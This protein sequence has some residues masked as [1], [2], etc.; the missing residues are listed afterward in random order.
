ML[1]R[2]PARR[3]EADTANEGNTGVNDQ[4][5]RFD[6]LIKG[7]DVVDPGAGLRGKLDVAIA[8][9]KVAAVEQDIDPARASQVIDASGQ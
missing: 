5:Q 4:T 2:P 6:I 8:G 9:G 7:G 3:R 1:L